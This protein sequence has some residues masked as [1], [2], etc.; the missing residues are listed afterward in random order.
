MSATVPRPNSAVCCVM[1]CP[2][3]KTTAMRRHIFRLVTAVIAVGVAILLA[4]AGFGWQSYR[5]SVR[6]RWVEETAVPEIARLIQEDRGLAALKLFREAEQYAPESRS[7]IKLAEGVASRPV[8]FETTPA[9]AEIYISDYTAAAGDDLSQWQLLGESP[10]K[11]DQIPIWGY[12]RVRAVKDGFAPTDQTFGGFAAVQLK[13]VEKNSAPPGM[14]QVPAT[15]ATQTAPPSHFLHSGWI[16][17]E[18]TNREF[19]Q[20][21]DAGGYRKPE[22]WKQLFVKDGRALSWQQAMD[23][24]RDRTSTTRTGNLATGNLSRGTADMPV[25]GIS[26]YEA[27]AYA[28]FAGKSLPTVYEWNQAAGIGVNSDIL[29]L[30][31]FN[32]KMPAP[33]G[34][35]RGMSPFGTLDMA[36][37]VKEWTANA[38]G[39]KRYIL[40]GAW[41]EPGYQFT[42]PDASAPFVRND[43]FGLRCVLRQ[44]PPPKESFSELITPTLGPEKLTVQPISD[45]A[46]RVF[47][48]LNAYDKSALDSRVEH[49]DDSSPYW[50]RETVSFKAAY[51]NER[52]IAHLFLPK[53]SQPPYQVVAVLG[54]ATI[55]NVLKRVEDFD[56]PVPVHYSVGSCGDYS[57]FFRNA[58]KRAI[59]LQTSGQPGEGARAQVV[60]G[61]GKID[62]LP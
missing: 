33:V 1:N 52:V 62:R 55:T 17:I 5:K 20:F 44:T 53:N 23:E 9:G 56:Y 19:K 41:D 32:G 43:T 8:S 40:G 3:S 15:A 39:D 49:V 26:W 7:L 14:V 27:A 51:G 13:L 30:S 34:T 31:N 36:G 42:A 59:A 37:N 16:A 22:Y 12:Y 35:H 38:S 29:Q 60:D 58:G 61:S 50:R 48:N 11:F 46:L 6:A 21:V 54:G 24:F 10:L 4:I 2:R 18:V 25:G 28:E 47:L 45:D 57:G